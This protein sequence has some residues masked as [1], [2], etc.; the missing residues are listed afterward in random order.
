M[1]VRTAETLQGTFTRTQC[2]W[3]VTLAKEEWDSSYLTFCLS[4]QGPQP[5]THR[6]THTAT[7]QTKEQW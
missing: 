5:V 1:T 6:A 3:K 4:P 7:C 2:V